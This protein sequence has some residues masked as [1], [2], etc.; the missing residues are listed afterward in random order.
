M[1]GLAKFFF[2]AGTI[3]FIVL[4]LVHWL[5]TFMDM[6]TPRKLT[7]RDDA[8]RL[9][10]EATT[11]K[12]TAR[13]T[14]WKAWMGFNHSYSLG[15][16]VFGLVFLILALQ[17]FASGRKTFPHFATL[18]LLSRCSPILRKANH[19]LSLRNGCSKTSSNPNQPRFHPKHPAQMSFR[20]R[21]SP[22]FHQ[23]NKPPTA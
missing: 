14:M 20:A 15:A 2:I 10:M 9:A 7:P 4:G 21:L 18:I 19:F 3:P 13:T 16:I 23:A 22:R 17:N 1:M 11:P 5:Y 8:V 12:L 6:S